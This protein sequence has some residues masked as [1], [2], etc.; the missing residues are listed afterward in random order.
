MVGER[1]PV[2]E[3]EAAIRGVHALM[4]PG[5]PLP[6]GQRRPAV[7]FQ[8]GPGSGKTL[9][10]NVLTDRVNQYVPHAHVDFEDSRHDE[11]PHTLSV[12]AERLARYRPRYRRLRFPR[13]LIALLV[14]EQDL[15]LYDFEQAREVLRQ[16][17][18]Q[19]RGARWPQRFLGE[20]TGEQPEV[21]ISVGVLTLLFRLPLQLLASALALFFPIFPRR[22][23]R[24]FGHRDRGRTDH[25]LDTLIEL[26]AWAREV[27]NAPPGLADRSARESLDKLL[28]EA[29]LADL[30]D[31]PRRVRAL[32]TPLLLLDNVDA[33]AG[34]AFLGRLWEARPPLEAGGAAEP[35]TLIV[36]GRHATPEMSDATVGRLEDVLSEPVAGGGD[37]PVWLSYPLPDLTRSDIQR[38]LS[39]ASVRGPVHRRLARLVHEFSAGHPEAV[40]VLAAVLARLPQQAESVG[41]LLAQP[42]PQV[43]ESASPLD[44]GSVPTAEEWLLTRLSPGDDDLLTALARCSAARDEAG[45][46][47][48]SH[49]PD[50]VDTAWLQ[51]VHQ[52]APWDASA[53]AGSAVLRQL[54]RRRLARVPDTRVGWREVHAKL[55]DYCAEQ[56]DLAGRLYHQLAMDELHDV[57]L[58]LARQL[59]RMPGADWLAL[60]HQVAAAPLASVEDQGRQP[61]AL[62]HEMVRDSGA[63][64][65]GD[66]TLTRVVHLLAA[67]RIVGD[68]V[69]GTA[70]P[71]LYTQ[72]ANALGALAPRSPDGLVV[73]QQSVKEYQ[74]QAL[75]WT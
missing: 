11:I 52:V 60:L 26:N 62:F 68:P 28:C 51:V 23:Q 2:F 43:A 47:W 10:L 75:W 44:P 39:D 45:G 32:P 15:T 37:Y 71:L 9:L 7:F 34:R 61:H 12:L 48:L 6:A 74:A 73:L 24:W 29:F 36:T 64:S 33:P 35:L 14:A 21:G 5:Y 54:L 50:L 69:N 30:R 72:V 16:H 67:L 3:R 70:R 63:A 17:L 40:G 38:L 1:Q 19:R 66:D 58:E 59:P 49:Q 22:S 41:E 13:L 25:E 56:G 27:R 31:A 65:A 20:L 42:S 46:L 55:R 18:K 53:S 8:G 4:Q 57:A